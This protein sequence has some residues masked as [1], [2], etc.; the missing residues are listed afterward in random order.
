MRY[1]VIWTCWLYG[2]EF[3]RDWVLGL[4]RDR[5]LVRGESVCCFGWSGGRGCGYARRVFCGPFFGVDLG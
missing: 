5:Q 1:V 4:Y 2:V 3:G